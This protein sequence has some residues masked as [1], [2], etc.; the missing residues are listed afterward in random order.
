M[1]SV[2]Y[3]LKSQSRGY[4]RRWL[5][6]N[7]NVQSIFQTQVVQLARLSLLSSRWCLPMIVCMSIIILV[8]TAQTVFSTLFGFSLLPVA[9][10]GFTLTLL[11]WPLLVLA[12]SEREKHLSTS[13]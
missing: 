2:R 5:E 4:Y 10:G 8:L 7:S 3:S 6:L 11:A 12:E 1:R 9:V 13:R